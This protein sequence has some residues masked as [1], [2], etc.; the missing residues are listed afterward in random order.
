MS[1]L[2][3]KEIDMERTDRMSCEEELAEFNQNKQLKYR[4]VKVKQHIRETDNEGNLIWV[5]KIFYQC[6]HLVYKGIFK[7]RWET[8]TFKDEYGTITNFDNPREII[9]WLI[10]LDGYQ[11]EVI[12]RYGSN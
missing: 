2:N 11:Y 7:R 6:E 3:L 12:K 4:I 9:D 1:L 8:I 10:Y 5:D